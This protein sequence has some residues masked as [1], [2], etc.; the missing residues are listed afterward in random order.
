MIASPQ[1]V[2]ADRFL[3]LRDVMQIVPLGRS[4][5]YARMAKGEFP[6]ARSLGGNVSAWYESEVREWMA[7]RGAA[8]SLCDVGVSVGVSGGTSSQNK[9]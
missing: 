5:I 1:P 8:G 9:R 6:Q 3:R 2:A 4:T 7:A